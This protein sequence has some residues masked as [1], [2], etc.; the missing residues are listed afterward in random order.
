MCYLTLMTT[1]NKTTCERCL[2][3]LYWGVDLY[4]GICCDCQV[5]IEKIE[6]ALRAVAK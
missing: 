3:Q 5:A 4:L 1:T 6:A 2:C